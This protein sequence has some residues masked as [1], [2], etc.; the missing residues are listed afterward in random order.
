MGEQAFYKSRIDADGVPHGALSAS[1]E[2][3]DRCD[4]ITTSM[5]DPN[6]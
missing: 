6:V 1:A 5:N 4:L 3:D 2:P